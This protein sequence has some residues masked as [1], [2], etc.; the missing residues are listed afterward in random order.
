[1]K[2]IIETEK[3]SF[4]YPKASKKILDSI[5]IKIE[6]GSITAIAGL[7]GSGKST[8]AY[9]LS[10]II[11]KSLPGRIEGSIYIEGTEIKELILPVLSKKIGIVF[12]DV[13]N[14]LFLPT[15]EAEI[16]FAP[17]NLGVPYEEIHKIIERTLSTLNIGHLRY[18]N[19]S[20]LSGG[21]KH[22]VAIAS[23]LSL[24]PGIIILDEVLSELDGENREVVVDAIEMLK[25]LGKT[26]IIIDHGIENLAIADSI[27]LLKNGMIVDRIEVD[28]NYELLYNRLS[29]FF[30]Y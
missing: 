6:E 22:L 9:C 27:L 3:L 1:M 24:N 15:T 14:Q 7:S 23:I 19:P 8:L 28:D 12:Q 30:L 16:A 17:E 20:Q 11:P 5:N 26:V 4:Y 13:D 10:G 25:S 2:P 21:E 18:R 29:D